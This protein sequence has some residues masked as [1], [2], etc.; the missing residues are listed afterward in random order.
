MA[1]CL[2]PAGG[3]FVKPKVLHHTVTI[4]LQ[5]WLFAVP[6]MFPT[7]KCLGISSLLSTP[8]SCFQ[9]LGGLESQQQL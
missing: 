6:C 2:I 4:I 8:G 9:V 5:S 1:C 3:Q 7:S